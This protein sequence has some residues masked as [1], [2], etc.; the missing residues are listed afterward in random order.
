M[1]FAEQLKAQLNIID[2]IGQ[3]VPLKKQGSGQRY[4]GLCP[5]HSENP[6]SFSVHGA[7]GFYNCFGCHAKG[8]FSSSFRNA[9]S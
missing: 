1:D 6:P 2:V 5:F 7:L 3:Y 9:K 4:V 8:T